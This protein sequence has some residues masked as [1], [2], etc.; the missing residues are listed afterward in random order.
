[1]FPSLTPFR[2]NHQIAEREKG[3]A[4][5]LTELEHD[6][7][8]R[9]NQR[10]SINQELERLTKATQHRTVEEVEVA[11]KLMQVDTDTEMMAVEALKMDLESMRKRRETMFDA[12]NK[13]S[14]H[15][16]VPQQ[17]AALSPAAPEHPSSLNRRCKK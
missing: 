3:L 17:R 5:R 13:Q 7:T 8:V 14:L 1:V 11:T 10:M 9:R 15:L 16:E 12:M 2:D 4:A 6:E